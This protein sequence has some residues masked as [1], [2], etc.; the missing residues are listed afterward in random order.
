MQRLREKLLVFRVSEGKDH[1]AFEALYSAYRPKIYQFVYFKVSNQ[2]EVEDI[3]AQV[4]LKAWEY[5]TDEKTKRVQNFRAFIYQ[6]TRNLVIDF[7]RRQGRAPQQVELQTLDEESEIE[8]PR[9]AILLNKF[10]YEEDR[11]YLNKYLKDIKDEYREAVIL[12]YLEEATIEEIAE[13][14]GKTPGNVRVLI[15][16]GLNALRSAVLADHTSQNQEH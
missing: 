15:H 7:Y 5:L 16:R 1:R 12:R 9:S 8:D 6:L 11:A 13:I 2:E 10:L 14:L 4:F 3:A